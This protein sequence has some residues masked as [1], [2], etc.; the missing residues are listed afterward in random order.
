MDQ[1]PTATDVVSTLGNAFVGAFVDAV[2]GSEQ[3]RRTI[4]V[5]HPDW[6]A[7]FTQRHVASFLH[8]R[9]WGRMLPTF[10]QLQLNTIDK[11]PVREVVVG[12]YSIRFKRHNV[13]DDISTFPTDSAVRFWANTAQPALIEGDPMSLAMGYL[14]DGDHIV[15]PLISLRAS[16]HEALWV[17]QLVREPSGE[18]T[19]VIRPLEAETADL[20]DFDLTTLGEATI[21]D[22]TEET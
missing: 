18:E 2:E 21:E 17:R 14:W 3:D 13:D 9:L 5:E 12:P 1:L 22:D 8:E 6:Y 11:E 10:S 16:I 4:L 7:T 15:S 19:P 20:P